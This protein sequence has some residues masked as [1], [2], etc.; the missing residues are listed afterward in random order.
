[1]AA[2]RPHRRHGRGGC[3]ATCIVLDTGVH[4]EGRVAA[5]RPRSQQGTTGR[6][7][8]RDFQHMK[9]G[10]NR[11]A[12]TVVADN[13]FRRTE[14]PRQPISTIIYTGPTPPTNQHYYIFRP[15]PANQSRC[16]HITV[17]TL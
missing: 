17:S 14:V 9:A 7:A 5:G 15:H 1:M 3:S 12:H 13:G 10:H 2:V 11:D 16:T 4:E 8:G 6:P